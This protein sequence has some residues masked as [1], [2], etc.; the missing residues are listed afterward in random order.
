LSKKGVK[1]MRVIDTSGAK[2]PM[3][4]IKFSEEEEDRMVAACIAAPTDA[5][6]IKA[7]EDFPGSAG[8]LLATLLV[9]GLDKLLEEKPNAIEAIEEEGLNW[10]D[11]YIARYRMH[12]FEY[13]R[14]LSTRFKGLD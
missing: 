7:L 9:D 14:E 6:K 8:S 2:Y 5:E 1:K 3:R 10:I 13:W 12:E 4:A 11:V